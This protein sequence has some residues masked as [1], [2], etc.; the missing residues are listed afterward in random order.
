LI[1]S[2]IGFDEDNPR[3]TNFPDFD[4]F[5]ARAPDDKD[6]LNGSPSP[7]KSSGGKSSTLGLSPI[8]TEKEYKEDDNKSAQIL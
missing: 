1:P 2:K 3:A 8:I 4:D 7:L 5:L 6:V